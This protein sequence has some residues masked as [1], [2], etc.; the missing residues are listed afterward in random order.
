MEDDLRIIDLEEQVRIE[1]DRKKAVSEDARRKYHSGFYLKRKQKEMAANNSGKRKADGVPVSAFA[2]PVG[3]AIGTTTE[4]TL[5][6]SAMKILEAKTSSFAMSSTLNETY[7]AGLET[8][9]KVNETCAKVNETYMAD[10]K[11]AKEEQDAK[12]AKL[13]DDTDAI[14]ALIRSTATGTAIAVPMMSA[15]PTP[16]T[17]RG[18]SR[19]SSPVQVGQGR[20]LFQTPAKTAGLMGTLSPV[21][22]VGSKENEDVKMPAITPIRYV[23]MVGSLFGSEAAEIFAATSTSTEL[24]DLF[25]A[26][27]P[28]KVTQI[29]DCP[30]V[31]FE[32]GT[33]VA[34]V[35]GSKPGHLWGTTVKPKQE[36][37]HL[38]FDGFVQSI[39]AC[40]NTLLASLRGEG[41][42]RVCRY[43]GGGA[44]TAPF[45]IAT[46]TDTLAF[47]GPDKLYGYVTKE[48]EDKC[49][50]AAMRVVTL[51]G[52][53]STT[54]TVAGLHLPKC[55]RLVTLVSGSDAAYHLAADGDKFALHFRKI[56]P[57][58]SM[59]ELPK[60]CTIATTANHSIPFRLTITLLL[61]S[62]ASS[63]AE[64]WR[65]LPQTLHKPMWSRRAMLSRRVASCATQRPWMSG[66][67]CLTTVSQACP[68]RLRPVARLLW[69][70]W[71]ETPTL[72]FPCTQRTPIPNSRGASS[73]CV[74]LLVV[75]F[76]KLWT[77]MLHPIRL[78]VF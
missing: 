45:G 12:A 31:L 29:S 39:D 64:L 35:D 50:H 73:T 47:L 54:T 56:H 2:T 74:R 11:S 4:A 46:G 27:K 58:S 6:Q 23:L 17:S 77:W 10:L 65:V 40:G 57:K 34:V 43:Q 48:L 70:L 15:G 61:S 42:Y 62:L 16:S 28:V 69:H 55:R 18:S 3:Q 37:R 19:S 33:V 53:T 52:D 21:D 9:A 76:W 44:F 60:V 78:V 38:V 68:P 59:W 14:F 32:D 72:F 20:M 66:W 75:P 63:A 22:S 30:V 7:M 36:I 25:L 24:S 71:P 67:P 41:E 51:D 49:N 13:D 26:K 5:V 1:Q 8:G